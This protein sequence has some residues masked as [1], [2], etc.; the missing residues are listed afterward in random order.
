MKNKSLIRKVIETDPAA[1]Y[2]LN[3]IINYP[4]VHAMFCY[5]IN[6]FL[7]T[8]LHLKL[9]ARLL[10]QIARFFTGIEIHPGATIG[11]RLFIDH[12]MGVV[13]GET[14]IIGD[15]CVLYQGVTLGG[16][17]TGEHKVKRHPTL[18]NNVMV[19]AGAKVIGDVTIGNNTILG[20]Q[21]VVLKDVPDNCTVVG[22]P[23]FIVKEN[24]VKV[25][26]EL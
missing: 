17:G 19:S 22:V 12:G 7:W 10:S 16:V 6:N 13:I 26:K 15:D 21:T 24:G 9:L 2:A 1:R 8:K 20:A 23:A 3:V 4:G 18:L 25:K 5:R 14:T 11:K